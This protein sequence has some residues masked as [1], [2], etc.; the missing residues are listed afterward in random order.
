M[1]ASEW[2][3]QFL[4]GGLF[5]A[6]G[7]G[8]RV[9][10]GLKKL[11]ETAVREKRPFGDS[12]SPGLVFVSLLIG[13]VAGVLGILSTDLSLKTITRETI[14]LLIGVGYAGADF[15]EAFM[16]KHLPAPAVIPSEPG[17]V[18]PPAGG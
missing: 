17:G 13:F 6:L 10:V 5:G 18:K 12:F 14:V 16:R 3:M 2:V 11:N 9:V 1:T 4:V 7:Q 15:I 8:I